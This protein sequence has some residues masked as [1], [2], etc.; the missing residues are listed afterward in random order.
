MENNTTSSASGLPRRDFIKKTATAAAAMAATPLFKTPVYGQNQAPSAN[1]AGANNR[2]AVAVVG[3]GFG[4]GNNHLT[5]I[6]EKCADNNTVVAAACDVFKKRR[7]AAQTIASLKDGDVYVD[8][9]KLL[10]RKDIDAVLIATHDPMHAQITMDSLEAGKHVYCEKPLTRYLDEAFKVYDTVKR[11]GKIFQVG[12]QG[13]S[14]GGYHKCAEMIKAG[15]LGQLVWANVWYS[16]N[17][18]NGEWNYPVE[19]EKKK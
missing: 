1:V 6:H 10:E 15:K 9:K 11:A 17:S 14:A 16:R 8:Y 5:G 18:L 12:S 4:I 19:E 13:C 7:E 2:I 3:V